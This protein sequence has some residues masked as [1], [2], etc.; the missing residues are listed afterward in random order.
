MRKM[1]RT[2]FDKENEDKKTDETEEGVLANKSARLIRE[3]EWRTKG[4]IKSCIPPDGDSFL[5]HKNKG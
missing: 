2:L 5:K 3:E 4:T 1:T